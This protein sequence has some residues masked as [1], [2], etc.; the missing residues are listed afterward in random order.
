MIGETREMRRSSA[1]KPQV[2][3]NT[4][5]KLHMVAAL[6]KLHEKNMAARNKDSE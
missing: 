6:T 1:L 3:G 2:I 5:A 4:K